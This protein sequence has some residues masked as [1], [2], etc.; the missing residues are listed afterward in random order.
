MSV[1]DVNHDMVKRKRGIVGVFLNMDYQGRGA[2]FSMFHDAS[3][4]SSRVGGSSKFSQ[5][6][7]GL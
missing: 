5:S 4:V 7:S 6:W 2:V 1:R 3:V